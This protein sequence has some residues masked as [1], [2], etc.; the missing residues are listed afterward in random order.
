[1]SS[2]LSRMRGTTLME[3]MIVLVII[4]IL[5]TIAYPNYRKFSARAERTVAQA[6]L[7]A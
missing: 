3:I 4:G 1:M 5:T 2:I 7:A 6:G